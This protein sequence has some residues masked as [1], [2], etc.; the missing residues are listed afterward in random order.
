MFPA[1]RHIGLGRS[2][3]HHQI[4][5]IATMVIMVSMTIC[6]FTLIAD[7]LGRR[8]LHTSYPTT[9]LGEPYGNEGGLARNGHGSHFPVTCVTSLATVLKYAL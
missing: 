1:L 8:A 4:T 6:F 9:H 5:A 7:P 3:N 2:N